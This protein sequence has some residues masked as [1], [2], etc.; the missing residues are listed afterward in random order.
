METPTSQE[1]KELGRKVDEW[2]SSEEGQ[3]TIREGLQ[4]I[5]DLTNWQ[6]RQRIVIDPSLSDFRITI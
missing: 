5:S 6:L 3:K 2:L 4:R 1:L